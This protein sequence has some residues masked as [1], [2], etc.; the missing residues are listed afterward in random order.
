M[1]VCNVTDSKTTPDCFQKQQSPCRRT[2]ESRQ[3]SP[4]AKCAINTMPEHY[5][6]LWQATSTNY[7]AERDSHINELAELLHHLHLCLLFSQCFSIH[8]DNIFRTFNTSCII[9]ALPTGSCVN[10]TTR[11]TD[12][13]APAR[14]AASTVVDTRSPSLP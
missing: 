13:G 10:E 4:P 7:V 9:R 2:N 14:T 8:A 6:A 1:Y 5:Q 12:A 11:S 3:T